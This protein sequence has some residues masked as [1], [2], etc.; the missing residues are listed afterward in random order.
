MPSSAKDKRKL[1]V[2][3]PVRGWL[4]GKITFPGKG[5]RRFIIQI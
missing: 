4:S 2:E 1:V 3:R 5:K